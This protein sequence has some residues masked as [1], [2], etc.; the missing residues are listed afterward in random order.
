MQDNVHTEKRASGALRLFIVG[1]LTIAAAV[2]ADLVVRALAFAIWPI[3]PVFLPLQI[4][5]IS[6]FAAILVGIGV[7]VYALVVRF[8]KQPAR[9]YIII[10]LIALL[11]SFVP[12][13]MLFFYPGAR[14]V[15]PG[16]TPLATSILI[17]LHIIDAMIAI[18]LLTR[19]AP[20]KGRAAKADVMHFNKAEYQASREASTK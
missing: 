15:F 12:T 6:V 16:I 10:A 5:S 9:T 13:S 17:V 2:V 4:G 3:S 7:L 14:R 8:S 20:S 19:F 18:V 1:V 11:L